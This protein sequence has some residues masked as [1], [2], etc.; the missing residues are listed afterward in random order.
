MMN[1]IAVILKYISYVYIAIIMGLTLLGYAIILFNDG[2]GKLAET[3][4]P[5]NIWN[6]LVV[7]L[8]L[9]PG[10]LLFLLSEKLNKKKEIK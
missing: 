4:S 1:K 3:L 7:F 5:F 8:T 10:W 2:F 9:L 6:W